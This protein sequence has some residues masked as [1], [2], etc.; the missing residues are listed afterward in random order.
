MAE[1]APLNE[2]QARQ[3]VEF[4]RQCHADCGGCPV[5][6]VCDH[7]IAA[8]D[9]LAAERQAHREAGWALRQIAWGT[10][11]PMSVARAALAAADA[12]EQG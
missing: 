4:V 2:E 1:S 6:D 10:A 7:L 11:D 3:D 9:V 8:L 5:E 12:R